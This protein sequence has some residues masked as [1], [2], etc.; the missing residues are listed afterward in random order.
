[1]RQ[2]APKMSPNK[3]IKKNVACEA[4]HNTGRQGRAISTHR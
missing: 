2:P 3:K 4:P 1:M